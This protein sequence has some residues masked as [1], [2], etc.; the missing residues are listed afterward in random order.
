[1]KKLASNLSTILLL[2]GLSLALW[3]TAMAAT[4]QGEIMD[5]PCAAMGGHAPKG[6]QMTKTDN[7]KDCTLA[8]V[9]MMNGKYTLYDAATKTVHELDDQQ[10]GEEFAG[11]KVTVE[12]TQI[13]NVTNIRVTR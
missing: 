13:L 3:Q 7:P 9:R 8:C 5:S 11:Q 4:F 2:T 1:M 12:G 6:Y 10:R